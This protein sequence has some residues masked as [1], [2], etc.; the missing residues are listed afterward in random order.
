MDARRHQSNRGF[1]LVELLVVLA[2]ISIVTGVMVAEMRGT[3]QDSLLR[4]SA[5]KLLAELNLANTRSISMHEPHAVRIQAADH[6]FAVVTRAIGEEARAAG[7]REIIVDEGRWDAR[8]AV[9][10]RDPARTRE[11]AEEDA[12]E[13]TERKNAGSRAE[14]I[15]FFP[16][17]TAD[18]KEI[19]LRDQ[20][21]VELRLRVNPITGRVRLAEEAVP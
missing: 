19:V 16:D 9:E 3:Y 7:R 8:I 5:R 13:A 12:E 10:I 18:R 6:R 21:G 1:T 17:G 20:T 11:E 4:A 15:R 2:L 14:S